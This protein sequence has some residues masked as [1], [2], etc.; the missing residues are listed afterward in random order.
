MAVMFSKLCT[1][2]KQRALSLYPM[3]LIS[4]ENVKTPV[5]KKKKKQ[6]ALQNYSCII[7]CLY[8]VG[9]SKMI[10][11]CAELMLKLHSIG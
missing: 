3:K 8:F 10:C 5:I 4:L 1:E 2:T 11:E 9:Y 7:V 6:F